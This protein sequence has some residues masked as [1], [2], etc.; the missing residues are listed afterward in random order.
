MNNSIRN[1]III[2][3]LAL[4]IVGC[5]RQAQI[6][7]GDGLAAIQLY[8]RN[9]VQETISNKER[10]TV[11]EK[12]DFLSPQP[13]AKVV[14]TYERGDDGT[15]KAKVTTYHDNGEVWQYLDTVN[16][17][18]CGDF[19]EWHLNGKKR[20]QAKVIEGI[21][22]LNIKAQSSW[23]FD[24]KS[25]V[26]DQNEELI[27]EV[28]YEKGMLE[29]RSVYYHT[30]GAIAKV[31]P[32]VHDK[33]EGS[34]NLYDAEG[35]MIGKTDYTDGER[36]GVSEYKGS[37][38]IP[39]R[40]ELYKKGELISGRYWD[41]EEKV[42]SE[43][44]GG[45][46]SRPLFENGK[47]IEEREYING[48]P[49]GEV[50]TYRENG[51]LETVFHVIDGKKEGEEWCYY[52][53]SDRTK[54]LQPMLHIIWQDDEIHGTVR[55]WYENGNLES[56]KEMLNNKKNGILLAWY[57]DG[58]LMMVE[59]YQNDT[60]VSGKYFKKGE[61]S[62]MTRVVAGSGTATI[63]NADGKFINKIEYEEGSPKF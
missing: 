4:V 55:T 62:P 16:G 1:T 18:A 29:G 34:I 39:K 7:K 13:F 15:S 25:Y 26:W 5:G 40:E 19:F 36:D 9:G 57:K 54:T 63:Y 11:Y 21:G 43:I 38:F 23:V 56:E 44:E 53:S 30:N 42:I 17:R 49:E 51:T 32:Y 2:C 24:G 6:N 58:N 3:L 35:E 8:D 12:S 52:D 46:G 47:L 48:Y 45:C 22:D 27:A 59:E 37:N 20:L 33:I 41:F 60:L 61:E 14:R 10:T 28:N 31:I 50:K